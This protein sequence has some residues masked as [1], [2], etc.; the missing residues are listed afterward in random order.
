MTVLLSDG[1][2]GLATAFR[3]VLETFAADVDLTR[4]VFLKPNI[5]FAA[6]PEGGDVTPPSFVGAFIVALRERR[7][8][9]DI[10]TGDGVAVGCDPARNFEV[11]GYARLSRELDVPLV[12]LHGAERTPVAWRSGELELPSVALERTYINVPILKYSSACVVSGALKNQK[13]LLTPAMKKQ[14]HLLGLHELIAELNVAVKPS[15]TRHGLQPFLRPERG[16]RRGQLRRGRRHGLPAARHRGA[17][18]RAGGQKRGRVRG[19]VPHAGR[20]RRAA[21][22][23]RPS[24][25][26]G[27]QAARTAAPVV[28][29]AG[30]HGLPGSLSGCEGRCSEARKPGGEVEAAHVFGTR[31]RD[32][33]GDRPSVA[34]G[35]PDGDLR[36]LLHPRVAKDNGYVYVPGCPPSLADLYDH[37]P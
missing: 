10:V 36:R 16:P 13:G 20:R 31:R 35:V 19:R 4:G 6:K 23:G 3:E 1:R 5:V 21:P 18:A 25:G 9:L 14:F 2:Q 17:G 8:G 29:S 33:H 37:L 30:L 24:G 34:E 15:L 32:S 7:P 11:S 28:Q 26:P 12:D 27:G 22:R